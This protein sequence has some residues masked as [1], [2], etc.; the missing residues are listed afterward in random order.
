VYGP[1][2][3]AAIE[4]QFA[5]GDLKAIGFHPDVKVGT[6]SLDRVRTFGEPTQLFFNVNAPDDLERAEAMWRRRA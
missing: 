2:C 5:R 3:A 4:R 1:A 6:L